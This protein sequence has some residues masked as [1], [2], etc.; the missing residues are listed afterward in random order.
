M[1]KIYQFVSCSLLG[2]SLSGLLATVA[3]YN[4]SV[5]VLMISIISLY[6]IIP[7]IYLAVWGIGI[8]YRIEILPQKLLGIFNKDYISIYSFLVIFLIGLITFIYYH[9]IKLYG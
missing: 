8:K 2:F 4:D 9:T 5:R 1:S 3:H 6:V 7:I